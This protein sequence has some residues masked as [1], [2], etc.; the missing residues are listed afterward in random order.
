MPSDYAAQDLADLRQRYEGNDA[1]SDWLEKQRKAF[2]KGVKSMFG[3]TDDGKVRSMS[4]PQD[5]NQFALAQFNLMEALGTGQASTSGSLGRSIAGGLQSAW[6][7][8]GPTGTS[9]GVPTISPGTIQ[10]RMDLARERAAQQ[11]RGGFG[12]RQTIATGPGGLMGRADT[13]SPML[14]GS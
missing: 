11:G 7:R 9:S 5:F 2:D 12:R 8:I 10:D 6:N 1:F 3:L 14:L 13:R 4:R